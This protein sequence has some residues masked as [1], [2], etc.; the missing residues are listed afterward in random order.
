MEVRLQDAP[1][2]SGANTINICMIQFSA[3]LR[4]AR[5]GWNRSGMKVKP[6]PRCGTWHR[7]G[8]ASNPCKC[9]SWIEH[10]QSARLWVV[11]LA[12]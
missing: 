4:W 7:D 9:L 1:E 12:E 2:L 8:L 6:L 5:R 3:L 10:V 11:Y